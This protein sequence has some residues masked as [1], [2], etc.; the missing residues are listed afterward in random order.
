MSTVDPSTLRLPATDTS[1]TARLSDAGAHAV[2]AVQGVAFW[3]TIPLP[4]VIVATLLTGTVASAPVL[5]VGLVLLNVVCAV[6]GH[7]YS[8]NA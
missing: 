5:V 1:V 4:L 3:A 8:P 2:T 7:T 6:L